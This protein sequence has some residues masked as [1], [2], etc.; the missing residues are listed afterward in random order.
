M[1]TKIRIDLRGYIF[2][3]GKRWLGENK[4]LCSQIKAVLDRARKDLE[5][6]ATELC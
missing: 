3:G 5:L 6:R 1:A 4:E 2:P